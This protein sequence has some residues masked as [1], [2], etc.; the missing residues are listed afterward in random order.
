MLFYAYFSSPN[1]P[2]GCVPS[3]NFYEVVLAFMP[4]WVNMVTLWFYSHNFLVHWLTSVKLD[5]RRRLR[6]TSLSVCVC[7]WAHGE[8]VVSRMGINPCLREYW[9]CVQWKLNIA[10]QW[11]SGKDWGTVLKRVKGKRAHIYVETG[12]HLQEHFHFWRWL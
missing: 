7:V 4:C 1:V 9:I 2:A 5:S 6:Y 10:F 12:T 11:N 8:S 3:F